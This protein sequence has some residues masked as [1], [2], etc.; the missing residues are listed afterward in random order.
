[1]KSARLALSA[2]PVLCLLLVAGRAGAQ[3][4][5]ISACGM[6]TAPGSYQLTRNL[7]SAGDCLKVNN[8]EITIDLNGFVISNSTH[9]GSAITDG[10]VARAVLKVRDGTLN[11]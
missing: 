7:S 1:M 2:I 9:L 4:T 11:G 10:G 5:P 8:N 6:I 3:V